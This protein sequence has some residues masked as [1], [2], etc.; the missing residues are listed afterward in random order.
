[1]RTKPAPP[2]RTATMEV[3]VECTNDVNHSAV[4]RALR[5]AFGDSVRVRKTI[6]RSNDAFIACVEPSLM[7]RRSGGAR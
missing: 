7:T 6:H 1:M 2:K 4:V 5:D 3:H